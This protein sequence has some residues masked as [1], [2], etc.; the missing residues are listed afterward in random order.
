[1]WQKVAKFKVAE[2]FRKA[3]YLCIQIAIDKIN[4]DV[5]HSLCQPK[6]HHAHTTPYT[7]SAIY[8]GFIREEH[9]SPVCQ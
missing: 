7:L 9:N 3:L 1:M 5:V 6:P 2:Y 4:L 8:P